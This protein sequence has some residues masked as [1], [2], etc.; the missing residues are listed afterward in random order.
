LQVWKKKMKIRANF[1]VAGLILGAGLARGQTTPETHNDS[2]VSKVLWARPPMQA[3]AA[4]HLLLAKQGRLLDY[5]DDFLDF[6][7]S[8]TGL[9]YEIATDLDN[10]AGT[11]ADQLGAASTLLEIY[12]SM[13]CREDRAAVERHLQ[14]TLNFSSRLLRNRISEMNNVISH[15]RK[16][17]VA[18]EAARMR[19]DLREAVSI[20][21]S[22]KL[23]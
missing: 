5:G 12:D 22:V 10:T 4:G 15:T 9:E 16:P 14:T 6:A 2:G 8:S 7:K 17:G 23:Q 3:S 11:A 13:S 19:D 1:L 21:D 20:L 18:A